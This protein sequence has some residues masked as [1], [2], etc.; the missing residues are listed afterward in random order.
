MGSWPAG[1]SATIRR[2]CMATP[3]R[4]R[5]LKEVVQDI[6][7]NVQDIVHSEIRLAKAEI[8]DQAAKARRAISFMGAGALAGLY[9]VALVL[10]ACV[11][12]LAI[13]LPVWLAALI[14]GVVTGIA[15]AVF[16]R[17]GA[18][19]LRNVNTIPKRTIN[20]VRENAAW[21]RERTR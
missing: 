2:T 12:A 19:R 21:V 11:L 13:I 9:S 5:S 1:C 15:A 6:I 14:M 7:G 4:E 3:E 16:L 18:T 10:V 17:I 8:T 20:S